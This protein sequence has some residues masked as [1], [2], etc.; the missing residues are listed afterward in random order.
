MNP[1]G[2]W[3]RVFGECG[4]VEIG[5]SPRHLISILAP[6]SPSRNGAYGS[7]HMA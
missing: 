6:F 2:L 7:F 4:V 5:Y 1:D 3:W